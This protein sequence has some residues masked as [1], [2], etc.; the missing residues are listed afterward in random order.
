[1]GPVYLREHL[2]KV[3]PLINPEFDID[4]SDARLTDFGDVTG[5]HTLEELHELLEA[6][7]AEVLTTQH[8]P[9]VCGGGNDQSYRNARG[10]MRFLGHGRIAVINVDAHLDARP[11]LEGGLAHSGSP[12]RQLLCDPDFQG[13]FVEFAAQGSQCSKSHA[14]FVREKGGRIVWLR[15][16]QERKPST[17]FKE[18]LTGFPKEMP[19]FLS[20]DIDAIA[21]AH[22]PGVSCPATIGLSAQDALDICFEA[23]AHRTVQL[24]D[25]SEYNPKIEAYRTGRLLAN[26]MY[27]F[28]MGRRFIL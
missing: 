25:F 1:M 8:C 2:R 17:V 22:C 20:F 4:L 21:S 15:E 11:A 28:M 5:W 13:Q 27:Y 26:M 10:L 9:L 18:I 24:V 7:V 14:D 12:F 3:G 6:R 19:V 16:L 23:G